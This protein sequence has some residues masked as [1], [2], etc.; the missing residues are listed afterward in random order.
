[1]WIASA[2]PET[3]S[4]R[5]VDP[6]SMASDALRRAPD[7]S[8]ISL[9]LDPPLPITVPIRELGMMNLIVTA[10]EPGTDETSNGSSLMR[11]TISP[12]A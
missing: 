3:E 10:R 11:R 9:I 7:A 4:T 6:G 8:W 5:S 12:N 2:T 1:M